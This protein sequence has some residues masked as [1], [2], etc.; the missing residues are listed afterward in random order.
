MVRFSPLVR[1]ATRPSRVAK[2]VS[3]RPMPTPVPGRK[4]VPRWRTRIIPDLT[5]C[6]SNSF[7][8]SRFDCES[9]P[10]LEEPSPFLCAIVLVLCFQ[11]G[12]ERRER[13]LPLCVLLLV[14][15][16]GFEHG[17]VPALCTLG[18]LRNRHVGVVLR[19][20][21]RR[22]GLRLFGRSRRGRGHLL[23]LRRRLRLRLAADAR[24]L[25]PRQRRAEAGVAAVARLRLVLADP[26][27]RPAHVTDD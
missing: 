22:L 7:T 13:S 4:R 16:R 12:L 18:D 20:A 5:S 11:R 2:I 27:L 17:A 10:F 15:L 1:K 6:P 19:Q 25:D 9:R 8:P 14:N 23:L 26:N 21:L 24:D 3:S